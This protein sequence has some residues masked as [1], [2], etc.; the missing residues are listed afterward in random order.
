LNP[1]DYDRQQRISFSDWLSK[2]VAGA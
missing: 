2:N 1:D